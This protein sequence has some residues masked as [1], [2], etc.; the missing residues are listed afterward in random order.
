ME[1]IGGGRA[2]QVFALDDRKVLRRGEFDAAAEARLMRYLRDLGFPVPQVFAADGADL[3]ME[4]LHGRTL[5]AEVNAGAI[6]IPEAAKI[7]VDLHDRLHEIDAPADLPG[8]TRGIHMDG[9]G[10]RKVLHLDLH[11]ENV[12]VTDAGPFLID[13]TNAIAGAPEY[14]FAVSWAIIAGVDA[15][16]LGPELAEQLSWF[17]PARAELLTAFHERTTP[18]ALETAVAYRMADPNTNTAESERLRKALKES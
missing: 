7:L 2:S 4:R 1:Q 17:E 13:W 11:P 18:Q 5:G 16:D 12:I 8:S 10:V 15:T 3:T 6:G 9:A 14:D